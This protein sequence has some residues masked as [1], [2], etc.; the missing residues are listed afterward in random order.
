MRM[1][2]ILRWPGQVPAGATCAELCT[3]MD[4]YAT[5]ARLTGATLPADRTIDGKDAWALWSGG[6]GAKS[7]HAAFYFYDRGD[8]RAVRSG[9]W[10]LYLTQDDAKNAEAGAQGAR[11][12]DLVADEGEERD[13]AGEHGDV[14]DRLMRLANEAR[15]DLGDGARPGTNQRPAGWVWEATARIRDP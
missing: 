3:S 14:V 8:L 12:Y 7:P 10:K 1:P 15:E 2:C 5:F 4:F 11:L 13:V 9:P 6:P